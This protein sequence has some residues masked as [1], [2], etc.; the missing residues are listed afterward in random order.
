[1]D[2]HYT[3]QTATLTGRKEK[4]LIT[5]GRVI[6]PK[7][8]MDVIADIAVENGK[9]LAVET[10]PTDFTP[11]R[12]IN[13]TGKW[14]SPGL[15]DIHVHLREPGGENK[16]TIETGTRAAAAGG[17]TGVACMPNTNPITDTEQKI[18][19]IKQRS[20]NLPSRV[21]P[22]G[23]MTKGLSGEEI[24]PYGEMIQAGAVAV[25]DDGK[26]IYR[27]DML[28]NAVNYAKMFNIPV[29]CHCEDK[30][31]A[32]GAMN[33][34]AE[35]TRLG[36]PGIPAI[37]EDIDVAR[38]IM[39]AEYTNTPVHIC[40]VSSAGALDQIRRAKE[41]SIPVTAETAPHYFTY[42]DA[43]VE[44]NTYRKMN[45]PLRGKKDYE[46]ILAALR[47]GTLDAIASDHAPHTIEDKDGAFDTAAFGVVGLET[48]VG[49]ALTE[50]VHTHILTPSELISKLSTVPA[51]IIKTEGG[52]LAPATPADITIIDPDCEW[53]V[54][55][56]LFFSKGINSAFTGKALRGRTDTTIL[57]GE[58]VYTLNNLAKTS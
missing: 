11:D 34:S 46:A 28:K 52:S 37:S 23:S 35:S 33:E 58:I 13:A 53:V 1:M 2:K 9:I 18:R 49:V 3:G 48:T 16:E 27:S 20:R 54:D 24:A 45:P 12:T 29:L 15:I 39:I 10:I 41:R 17:F 25:S 22:V 31:L 32:N 4:I 19:Y 42:T 6:D 50:L 55:P 47:D 26:S 5:G 8:N 44:Y 30:D 43:D 38:H 7:Q 21:Y 40:H 56:Q 14:V 36:I 51:Q 57:D